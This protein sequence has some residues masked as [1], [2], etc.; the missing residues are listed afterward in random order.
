MLYVVVKHS[1][2]T[3]ELGDHVRKYGD[4]RITLIDGNLLSVSSD[5]LKKAN[6]NYSGAH[7]ILSNISKVRTSLSN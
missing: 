2:P 4:Y 7:L 5:V 1:I 6:N 3:G